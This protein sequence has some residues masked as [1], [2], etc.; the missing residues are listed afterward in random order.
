MAYTFE[1][2][3]AWTFLNARG[4]PVQGRRLTYRLDDGTVISVDVTMPEYSQADVVRAKLEEKIA[5]HEALKALG[6]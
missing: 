2:D 6:A 4:N 5:A 1:L 3:E